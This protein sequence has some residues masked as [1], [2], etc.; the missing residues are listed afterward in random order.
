MGKES[1][2]RCP[3][4]N[5]PQPAKGPDAIYYCP[6][7]RMQFDNDPNEGGDFSDRNAAIR[8]ERQERAREKRGIGR[9][10]RR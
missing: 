3:K 7:C 9:Q 5:R 6:T 4:C 8:L 10:V 2:V 1:K